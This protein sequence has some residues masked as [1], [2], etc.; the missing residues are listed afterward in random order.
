MTV[1][2][3]FAKKQQETSQNDNSVEAFLRYVDDIVNSVRGEP[4]VVQEAA[5][6]L[7][8]NLQFTI[9]ELDSNGSLTYWI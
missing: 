6:K 4:G 2:A 5:N 9:E 8:P 1:F 7:H 3:W